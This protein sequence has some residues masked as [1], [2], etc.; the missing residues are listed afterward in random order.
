MLNPTGFDGFPMA[1]QAFYGTRN[2]QSTYY[3]Y[4]TTNYVNYSQIGD[5]KK[6]A[7][8]PILSISSHSALFRVLR[9]ERHL[10]LD[11]HVIM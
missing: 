6:V 1:K 4:W 11:V 5:I 2:G 3:K 9:P 10:S 7:Y 8:V